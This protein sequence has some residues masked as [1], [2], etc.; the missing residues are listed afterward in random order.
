MSAPA[1]THLRA[2]KQPI[3]DRSIATVDALFEAT[4]QVL[5]RDGFE[6]LTT[7]GVAERAGISVGSLYQYF[8]NKQALLVAVLK[9]HLDTIVAAIEEACDRQHGRPLALMIEAVCS[10]FIEA[11]TRRID[12]SQALYFPAREVGGD[13]MV[14]EVTQRSQVALVRMLSTATDATFSDLQ[15]PA[16]VISTAL[17]GPVQAA[18]EMEKPASAIQSVQP[19][20]IDLCLGYLERIRLKPGGLTLSE[21]TS[22]AVVRAG[23]CG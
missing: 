7:T 9:R 2:R 5:L 19:H 18:M 10:A 13:A 6:K 11:K 1:R 23:N 21:G 22:S 3:Q 14:S 16:F 4:I 20:L 15:T 8:P 17:V 12:L